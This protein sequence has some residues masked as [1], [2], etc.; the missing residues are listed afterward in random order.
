MIEIGFNLYL[1][2]MEILIFL[3]GIMAIC[4]LAGRCY[5]RCKNLEEKT[6]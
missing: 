5:E 2:I 1:I 3:I 4:Y 6:K